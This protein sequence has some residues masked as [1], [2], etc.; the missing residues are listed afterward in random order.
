[1]TVMVFLLQFQEVKNNLNHKVK[2][3]KNDFVLSCVHL[4]SNE[5]HLQR[6]VNFKDV[7]KKAT[8]E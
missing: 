4:G 1:M 5:E 6:P 7:C 8:K 2:N 3:I